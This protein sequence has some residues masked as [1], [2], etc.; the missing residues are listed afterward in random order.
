MNYKEALVFANKELLKCNI[1]NPMLDARILLMHTIGLTLEELISNYDKQL[2]DIEYKQFI[3]LINRR[4]QFEPVAYITGVKEFYLNKFIVTPD[5]LIPRADTEILIDV[6]INIVQQDY[7]NY[8]NPIKI[9][10]LCTGSGCILITL[11]KNISNSVGIGSDISQEALNIANI[12][13]K[14]HKLDDRLELINSNC[15]ENIPNQKFDIIVS[16]PPYIA[17]DELSLMNRE[18][19]IYEP[20]EALFA[21]CKGLEFYEI[22]AINAKNFMNN[23]SKLILEHGFMQYNSINQI[24]TTHGYQVINSY[25]DLNNHPRVLSISKIE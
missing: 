1:E 7:L 14:L 18:S 16:N 3:E 11:L 20:K 9:L 17:D 12:N 4:C 6:V 15:F 23:H 13:A 5:V 19:L 22:I 2:T 10:D 24:F 21:N 25:S 8:N